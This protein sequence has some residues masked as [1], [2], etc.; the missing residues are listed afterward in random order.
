MTVRLRVLAHAGCSITYKVKKLV[1][2]RSAGS[3]HQRSS[4]CLKQLVAGHREKFS[5]ISSGPHVYHLHLLLT[6]SMADEEQR[7][8]EAFQALMKEADL[9]ALSEK[10][11][12]KQLAEALGIDITPYKRLISVRIDRMQ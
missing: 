5:Q 3:G 8:L 2:S 4:G 10:A 7:V 11:I 12:R 6:V 1:D 9:D